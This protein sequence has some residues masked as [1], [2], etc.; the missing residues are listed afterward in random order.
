[1]GDAL[2]ALQAWY[3]AR[4]DGEWEHRFGVRLGSLDNPGWQLDVDLV[5]TNVAGRHFARV[6][7]FRDDADW[8]VAFRD[9]TQFHG[10]CGA[11]QLGELLTTFLDWAE[12]PE[13]DQGPI[14]PLTPDLVERVQGLGFDVALAA[15]YGPERLRWALDALEAARGRGPVPQ[16][17]LWLGRTLQEHWGVPPEVVQRALPFAEAA[18]AAVRPPDGT[19]WAREKATGVLFTVLDVNEVRVQLAGGVAVPAHHWA[20]WEWL[21]APPDGWTPPTAVEEA[22][23][24]AQRAALARVAAWAAVRPRTAAELGEKLAALGIAPEAWEAYRA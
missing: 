15:R 4:C 22:A 16:P 6:E 18:A 9:E 19:R 3:A 7:R 2:A 1:M 14:A 12:G 10:A 13:P 17:A 21:E 8:V 5:D 23:E 24:V 20:G 11:L